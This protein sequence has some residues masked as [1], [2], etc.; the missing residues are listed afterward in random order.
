MRL[1]L[2]RIQ[3][4]AERLPKHALNDSCQN[5]CLA[6]FK[7]SNSGHRGYLS[8]WRCLIQ[9]MQHGLVNP[10]DNPRAQNCS[11]LASCTALFA[12]MRQV[13]KMG[14]LRVGPTDHMRLA[15]VNRSVSV[16]LASTHVLPRH[17]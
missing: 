4:A 11:V 14:Q 2:G 12:R 16:T 5:S 8:F 7:R 17:T 1:H 10:H 6:S 13:S 15:G 9:F 3:R